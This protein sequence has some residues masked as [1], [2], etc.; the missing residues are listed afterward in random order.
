MHLAC[1]INKKYI[2]YFSVM[3]QSILNNSKCRSITIHVL[4]SDLVNEDKEFIRSIFS[5]FDYV[6]FFFYKIDQENVQVFPVVADHLTVETLYRLMLAKLLPQTISKVLY[7]DSDMLFKADIMEVWST[8][9][10][11]YP[12]AAVANLEGIMYQKLDLN[13]KFDYFNAGFILINLTLWR[14]KEYFELF[15]EYTKENKEKIIFGDQDVLNGFF[16]G[17]WI[18]LH[19]KWNVQNSLYFT[20]ENFCEFYSEKIYEEITERPFGIHFSGKNKPWNLLNNQVNYKEFFDVLF[21]M[22][23]W[24]SSIINNNLLNNNEDIYIFGTGEFGKTVFNI[25]KYFNVKVSGFLDNDKSKWGS[26][27]EDS[28]IIAPQQLFMENNNIKLLICS[29]YY[30]EILKSL[31]EIKFDFSKITILTPDSENLLI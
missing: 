19:P 8:D 9:L 18:R 22:K 11:S 14:E 29:M 15:A 28:K 31:N 21:E 12:I 27:L 25:L 17:N 3:I 13:S 6:E 26:N 7:I 30:Q 24:D 4:H 20:K 1:S 2:K 10:G 5:E 23:V 16:K